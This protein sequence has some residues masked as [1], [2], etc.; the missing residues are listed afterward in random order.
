M[1]IQ[2]EKKKGLQKKHIPYIAGGALFIILV[3]WI[4]F[5]DHASTL[6]VDARG[7]S[8]GDVR[9]DQ[10]N[11]FVRVDG[12][13]QPITV[14]QLSPEEGGIVRERVVEE[15]A[16]VKK[17][18]IIVRLSNSSLDLQILDAEAQLAEKQNFLRNTQVTMEQDKLNNQLEKA[19][20]DMETT[21][22]RRAYNQQKK[23]YEEF[24]EMLFTHYGVSGPLMLTA[25]SYVGEKLISHPL[26]LVIDLKPALSQEQLDTLK[27]VIRAQLSGYEVQKRETSLMRTDQNGMNYLQVFLES[28]RHNGKS[29]GTIEQYRFHLSRMLSYVGK[30]VQEI[31]DDDLIDYMHKYK[32]I[33]KV[34]G[35]YLNSMRLVFNS[36]FRWL[37]RRKII[38]RNPVD[39]LEPIKYRQVV[40]KPLSPEELEKVRCACEQERDLAIVE[41]LYS[42]AVRV[43]E[44]VRLNREDISWESDDVMVLGKGNKERE[45]YLN[46]K[47]HLHLKQYLAG[48]TDNNPALFV[49]V[50]APHERLTRSGIEYILAGLGAAAGVENVHPHRFRRTAATDLL[51]MGMPIEQVQ[52]LLG[53]VKIET[54]RIYCT[55]TREQVRAS[56]RRYMSA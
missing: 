41:F 52:E 13:V 38:M 12:Q 32:Q 2:L 45:V 23:L 14:V 19:Q 22:A 24:G 50:K 29:E 25:S 26:K 34:S 33:R 55:V 51:R 39:G 8:I 46:A 1:D 44:L 4:I 37:Q 49:G 53:H 35:R 36:F 31:E 17:G 6:K 16:Q 43:S 5:G 42:S 40:K 11:D 10:F 7:L 18:D 21:R 9:Q 3:G 28:F 30:N 27:E 54:T 47:A 56:H 20:L 48:R 15:G